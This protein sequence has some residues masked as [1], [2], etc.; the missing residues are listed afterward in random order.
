MSIQASKNPLPALK[1]K[2]QIIDYLLS[3][4]LF[5]GNEYE[6]YAYVHD[7]IGRF[8]IT[9]KMVPPAPHSGAKLLEL[10]ANPYFVSLLLKKFHR[11]DWSG[12]NYFGPVETRAEA[13]QTIH[14]ERYGETHTFRY[15]HF[16]VEFDDF[17]YE[18]A[19]FDGVLFCEILEHL[20]VNPTFTLTEIHRILKPGGFVLVTTPNMLRWEHVWRLVRGYNIND[21][22]SGYGVYGRH[23]R[24]YAPQE[25]IRLLQDCGFTVKQVQLENTHRGEMTEQIVSNIRK[26]WREHIFALARTEGQRR[27]YYGPWLY[28]SMVGMKR[29]SSAVVVIG[30]NDELHTGLG[31]H[32]LDDLPDPTRWTQQA[33]EVFLRAKGG[34]DMVVVEVNP[35]P[36]ALGP[37]QVTL[38]CGDAHQDYALKSDGWSLL[39]LPVAPHEARAEIRLLIEVDHLRCP[40]TQGINEDGRQLG[41]MVRKVALETRNMN[42][43]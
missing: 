26:H 24:E 30:Q 32:L 38:R 39:H 13:E 21:P 14:S 6:G 9:V 18:D 5:K 28:R 16:N 33:A 19:S 42:E 40:A 31:W 7:A 34:E 29:V 1:T 27:F 37:V 10:G 17:P 3:F 22:Y 2:Q 12:A 23:N 35:G 25:L 4:D 41:V 36:P 15:A 11:Y 8:L 43:G 20:T